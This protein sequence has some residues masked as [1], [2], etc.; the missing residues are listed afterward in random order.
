MF[1]GDEAAEES[2]LHFV[3]LRSAYADNSESA[4]SVNGDYDGVYVNS[5]NYDECDVRPAFVLNPG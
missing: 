4:F 2:V 3:W 1:F 5:V